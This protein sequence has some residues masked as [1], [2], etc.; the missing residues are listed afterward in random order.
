MGYYSTRKEKLLKG[1]DSTSVLMNPSLIARYGKEFADTLH[2][3]I[4]R[5]M[6]N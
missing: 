5:N 2:R 3:D 1:F 4:R 6:R